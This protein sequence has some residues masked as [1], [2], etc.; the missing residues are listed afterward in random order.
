MA[1]RV[2]LTQVLGRMK[3]LPWLVAPICVLAAGGIIAGTLAHY[4]GAHRL[5]LPGGY[6]ALLFGAAAVGVLAASSARSVAP[7]GLQSRLAVALAGC[8]AAIAMA[9]ILLTTLVWSYGS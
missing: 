3:Q 7:P 5:G 6:A 8:V 4:A 2:G 9:G 1:L